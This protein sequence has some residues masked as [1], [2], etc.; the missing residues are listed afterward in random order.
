MQEQFKEAQQNLAK[1]VVE[2]QSGAGLV[3][4]KINGRHDVVG[5][6]IDDSIMSEDKSFVED[7]IAAAFNDAVR[8]LEEKS[9]ETMGSMAGGFKLPEGFKFPF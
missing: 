4:I 5:V 2:G 8:K 6:S 7:L 3:L 9:K 1:L